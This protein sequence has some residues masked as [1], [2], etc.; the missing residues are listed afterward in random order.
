MITLSILQQ[1]INRIGKEYKITKVI[2]SFWSEEY[3]S[4]YL[5]KS[6]MGGDAITLYTLF[7][8]S[9]EIRKTLLSKRGQYAKQAFNRILFQ[10]YQK[11]ICV[12]IKENQLEQTLIHA[13]HKEHIYVDSLNDLFKYCYQEAINPYFLFDIWYRTITK[14]DDYAQFLCCYQKYNIYLSNHCV[15]HNND[16]LN[17]L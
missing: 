14:L 15:K 17:T 12:F 9:Q 4:N 2:H 5:A 6:K 13:F 3:I 11:F 1:I 16:S 10:Y 7:Q 8:Y